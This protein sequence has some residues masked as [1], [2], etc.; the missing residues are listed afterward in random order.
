MTPPR[1]GAR[2]L[3]TADTVGG[4]WTY[5]LD[6]IRE[7][8]EVDFALATMGRRLSP[9]QWAEARALPNVE[10]FESEYRLEWMEEPWE[11]VRAAGDWLLG[12]ER[13][14]E[15][16][17]VHLNGLV[18]GSLPFAAPHLVVVHSDVLSWWQAVKGEPAPPAWDRYQK[19]VEESL[20]SVDLVV[21]P[22]HAMM[23]E[24]VRLYGPFQDTATIPNGRSGIEPGVKE[25]F[26]FAAGRMW[27]DAKNVGALQALDGAWPVHVAGEG[28]AMGRLSGPETLDWMARA[29]IYALPARYEPFGL[30][31]LEAAL[32]GC[33]LVLGDIPSLRE[34]WDGRAIFVA[35]DDA[36]AL[37]EAI[38][39]LID[40]PALRDRLGI[41][42]RER[43]L[44]LSAERFGA[45]YRALYESLW[46]RRPADASH[47][48]PDRDRRPR[49]G[50][51]LGPIG[52]TPMPR[53]P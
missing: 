9:D 37:E 1:R 53:T 8:R 15:P 45:G 31:V 42:A 5:A 10:I 16:E 39:G 25:P 27:D 24:A 32:A 40:D 12:L 30:S 17:L 6:L 11:D 19:A 49:L 38:D 52:G 21:A 18:H 28:S 41:A 33:A 2:V 26:V 13:E 36:P 3:M 7:L 43:A 20:R 23:A 47:G 29:S 35:P 50:T 51:S 14:F 48:R 34:N 4:V 44:D 22:S 46:H